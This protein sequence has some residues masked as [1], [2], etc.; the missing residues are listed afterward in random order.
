MCALLL[1]GT[2]GIAP[3]PST[4]LQHVF[5]TSKTMMMLNL[6][7]LD[8]LHRIV[9]PLHLVSSSLQ[10]LINPFSAL[11]HIRVCCRV[12]NRGQR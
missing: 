6:S 9:L 1:A 10:S 2:D 5:Y 12:Y 7:K 4:P 11:K 8:G 3:P